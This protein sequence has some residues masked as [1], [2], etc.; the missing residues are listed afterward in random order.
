MSLGEVM[1]G[2]A[3][4]LKPILNVPSKAYT[5]AVGVVRAAPR[6]TVISKAPITTQV[7][8]VP[9]KVQEV[10]SNPLIGS[11]GLATDFW[12]LLLGSRETKA[13]IAATYAPAAVTTTDYDISKGTTTT[14]K[15]IPQ[16]VGPAITQAK[17]TSPEAKAYWEQPV[18][19]PT[20]I[21]LPEIKLP[22]IGGF[23]DS[24]GNI[25]KYALLAGAGFIAILILTRR[26]E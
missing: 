13:N 23:L 2:Q 15:T 10:V 22:D 17:E 4:S 7:V 20:D 24:L 3:Q 26:Q 21:T 25:G 19:G 8:A 12:N 11:I 5:E 6:G 1:Q 16:I 9:T 18:L 14:T